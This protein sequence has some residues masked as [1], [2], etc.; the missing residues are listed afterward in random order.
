MRSNTWR[1]LSVIKKYNV[2]DHVSKAKGQDG[3]AEKKKGT[4]AKSPRKKIMMALPAKNPETG[5]EK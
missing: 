1:Q 5:G 2:S 3:P 4:T